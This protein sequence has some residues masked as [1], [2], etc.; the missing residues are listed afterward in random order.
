MAFDIAEPTIFLDPV[1]SNCPS[2]PFL[3]ASCCNFLS[4][5]MSFLSNAN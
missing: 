1:D 5:L 4:S 3:S 2:L